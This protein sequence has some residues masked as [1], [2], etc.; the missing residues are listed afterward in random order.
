MIFYFCILREAAPNKRLTMYQRVTDANLKNFICP[1][2]HDYIVISNRDD[3]YYFL[4]EEILLKMKVIHP[5]HCWLAAL[6]MK[7]AVS[8]VETCMKYPSK[9]GALKDM[10]WES[11]T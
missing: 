9:W 2:T 6:K 10:L 1:F 7:V 5:V 4:R 8:H 3:F 11:M